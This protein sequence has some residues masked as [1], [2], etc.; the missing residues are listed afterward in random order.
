MDKQ[1][2]DLQTLRA[3]SKTAITF[4]RVG[5]V[6]VAKEDRPPTP[7]EVALVLRQEA[8]FGCCICGNPII[9]YHHIIPYSDDPH[10]RPEDMMALCVQHHDQATH[11]AL[12]EKKQRDAKANPCNKRRGFV[13]G[14]L[15]GIE[16]EQSV[17]FGNVVF[18]G[19]GDKIR[20]DYDKIISISKGNYDEILLTIRIYDKNRN[21][22]MGIENNEWKTGDA[23]LWDIEH[24]YQYLRIREAKRKILFEVDAS[25]SPISIKGHFWL[26]DYEILLN[27]DSKMGRHFRIKKGNRPFAYMQNSAIRNGFVQLYSNI[28][29]EETKEPACISYAVILPLEGDKLQLSFGDRPFQDSCLTCASIAWL[30]DEAG[31]GANRQPNRKNKRKVV[32][33]PQG[34]FGVE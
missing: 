33:T 18:Y 5:E 7:P 1:I 28:V 14:Q 6:M 22:I 21:L 2:A 29:H 15:I 8:G 10:F 34:G 17:R 9:Q 3:S 31:T 13:G 12:K 26:E 11:K 24:K 32:R 19:E 27:A 4:T 23:T 25:V 16:G 20:L 30:T